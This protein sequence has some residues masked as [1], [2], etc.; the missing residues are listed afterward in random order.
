MYIDA[1]EI[2]PGGS[3]DADI[4]IVGAGP[5][6]IALARQLDGLRARICVLEGGDREF[7]PSLNDLYRGTS[8]G[9]P[10]FQ[11]DVC[12]LRALGGNTNGWGGWCRPLDEIDFGE[13]R[14]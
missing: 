14:W 1:G 2:G 12:Q 6:G 10:Y 4:C 11:L 13:R 5:A 9:L 8:V 7:D 3:L